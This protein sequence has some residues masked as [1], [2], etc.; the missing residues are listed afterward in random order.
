MLV[1][2]LLLLLSSCSS[3]PTPYQRANPDYGYSEQQLQDNRFRVSFTGNIATKREAVENYL[4]Y[5]A[6]ELTIAKNY[7][8][9]IIAEQDTQRDTRYIYYSNF[10]SST[11][12][13]HAGRGRSHIVVRSPGV[14]RTEARPQ[15]R[16]EAVAMIIMSLGEA[17]ENDP[18]VFDPQQL[19]RFLKPTIVRPK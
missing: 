8:Y 14:T 19:I 7:D 17:P 4:L 5:R 12:R 1:L 11:I 18:N 15:N 2:A 13:R 10:S 16:Y 6:A 3:L 9:F